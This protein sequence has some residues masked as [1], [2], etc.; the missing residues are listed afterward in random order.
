[1]MVNSAADWGVADPCSIP[2]VSHCMAKDG[3]HQDQ[4]ERLL[5]QNPFQ[6]YH[7]SG[8]FDPRLDLPFIHPSTYQR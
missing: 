6:F 2:K 5:F 7:Q 3:F 8:K 4:I 1:M